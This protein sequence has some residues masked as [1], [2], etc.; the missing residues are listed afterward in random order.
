VE[1]A[2]AREQVKRLV[3]AR[4]EVHDAGVGVHVEG[5]LGF[6]GCRKRNTMFTWRPS[7]V[8]PGRIAKSD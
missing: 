7:R 3:P 1:E 2:V 5:S 6:A 4:I 8:R